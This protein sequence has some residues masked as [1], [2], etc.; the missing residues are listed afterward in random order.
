[1]DIHEQDGRGPKSE[2]VFVGAV[3]MALVASMVISSLERTEG[4]TVTKVEEAKVMVVKREGLA[5]AGI[6]GF[7]PV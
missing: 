3:M 4:A 5:L 2:D 1:M 6:A 7:G